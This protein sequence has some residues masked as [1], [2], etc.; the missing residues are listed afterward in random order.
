MKILHTS[1]CHI[2]RQFHNVS[3]LEDQ[4]HVL[5][6]IV[7]IAHEQQVD[8]ILIAGDIYDRSVPPSQAVALLDEVLDRINQLNIPVIL[9]S[10]NHDGAERLSFGSA[11]LA[12]SGVHI[13]GNIQQIADP[14]I[15]EDEHGEVAFFGLPYADPAT[16]RHALQVEASSHDEAMAQLM[17]VI[18]PQ[19]RANL[20]NSLNKSSRSV[21]L[22]HCFIDGGQSSESERPLSIGGADRVSYQHFAD[23]SYVALGHLHGRQY[24]GSENIRYSGSI[25]K[26]S[27]SEE[28]QIKSVT[29]VE[30]GPS[31][32]QQIDQIPLQPLRDMRT[33]TG[34]LADIIED[35]FNDP[36]R[37]DY[38]QIRLTDKHAILDVMGKLRQVYPNVLHIERPGL[39]A[40][41]PQQNA[42][43]DQLKKGEFSM[44]SDFF[45]QVNGEPL[46]AEQ[47]SYVL[48][49]LADLHEKDLHNKAL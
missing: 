22:S 1:D 31:G 10:G 19:L 26:Y 36:K 34:A 24:K 47:Q 45:E 27:F 21:L 5:D 4:R 33:I 28:K 46:S 40:A 49:T 41:S 30:M 43:R 29:L 44:F 12:Q 17:A 38:L 39:M 32:V 48:Q 35:A 6:Q 7:T 16:V 20:N 25:L 9:I 2:G 23:F 42:R 8:V 37:D 15:L 3:L 11:Q 13:L 14:V 18:K